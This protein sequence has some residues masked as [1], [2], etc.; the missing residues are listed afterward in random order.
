MVW[1]WYMVQWRVRGFEGALAFF[2][3]G[4]RGALA[5][6]WMARNF[7]WPTVARVQ[8]TK[9]V[10]AGKGILRRRRR[11]REVSKLRA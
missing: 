9:F 1:Y 6:S 5:V 8:Q 3:G 4:E 7:D 2:L 10:R 11:R